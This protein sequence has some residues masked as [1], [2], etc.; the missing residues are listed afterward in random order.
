MFNPRLNRVINV[1]QGWPPYSVHRPGEYD[2]APKAVVDGA[3]T[4]L[5]WGGSKSPLPGDRLFQATASR[6]YQPFGQARL[7]LEPLVEMPGNWERVHVNDP[8]PLMVSSGRWNGCWFLYYSGSRWTEDTCPEGC[9]GL[10]E[11]GVAWSS[12]GD[13]P[14]GRHGPPIVSPAGLH[15]RRSYG[16]GQPTVWFHPTQ[17]LFYMLHTDTTGTESDPTV[18]GPGGGGL[19]V[20]RSSHYAF[21]GSDDGET[22]EAYDQPANAWRAL[23]STAD[24]TRTAHRFCFDPRIGGAGGACMDWAWAPASG[25]ILVAAVATSQLARIYH[26]AADDWREAESVTEVPLVGEPGTA[27]WAGVGLIKKADGAVYNDGVSEH[28]PFVSVDV[29]V[30]LMI[31]GNMLNVQMRWFGGDA[32]TR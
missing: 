16:A 4:R 32:F 9:A 30:A 10:T 14:W 13:A 26:F 2:Y 11:I 21:L 6:F 31:N 12:T 15:W 24:V 7:Q 20:L 28:T 25:Q 17:Q 8:C 23:T 27:T 5:F 19:Y 22:L 1:R 29:M 3:I 18:P